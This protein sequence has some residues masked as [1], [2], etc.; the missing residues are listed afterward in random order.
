MGIHY[1]T[2]WLVKA[3]SLLLANFGPPQ[4]KKTLL[5]E[6]RCRKRL[7]PIGDLKFTFPLLSG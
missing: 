1:N 5:N 2:S 3:I 6:I 7:L 4:E